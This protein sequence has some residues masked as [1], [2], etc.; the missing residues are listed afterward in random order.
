MVGVKPGVCSFLVVVALFALVA[1][2]WAQETYW[3][4]E[5]NEDWNY[6][7]LSEGE[8]E[9]E[10]LEINWDNGIPDSG[11]DAYIL[12]GSNDP[13]ISSDAWA[14][15]LYLNKTLTIE[16]SLAV[17]NEMVVGRDGMGVV[18]Q[19]GG[20]VNAPT[21]IIG[22]RETGEA[23]GEFNQT[24]G[25]N[26]FDNL[27]LGSRGSD[28]GNGTYNLNSS[29][30]LNINGDHLM[31]G[32]EGRGHFNHNHGYI[33]L[34][35]SAQLIIGNQYQGT[36][37]HYSGQVYT[38][39]SVVLGRLEGSEGFYNMLTGDVSGTGL[40]IGELG[41]NYGD[42]CLILGDAGT[43]IFEQDAGYVSVMDKMTLGQQA[44][45][46]GTYAMTES[47]AALIVFN[48]L[49]VGEKGQGFMSQ[50][51]GSLT[52]NNGGWG[53]G[54]TVG[55]DAGSYGNFE[56]TGGETIVNGPMAVGDAGEGRFYQDGG[57]L[58]VSDYLIV[59]AQT[60]SSGTIIQELQNP[61]SITVGGGGSP[62]A[63]LL[64]VGGDGYG[65]YQM[66]GGSLEVDKLAIGTGSDTG[67]MVINGS[68]ASVTIKKDMTI[69]ENGQFSAGPGATIHMTGSNFYNYS[70]DSFNVDMSN[71]TM[72]FEGGP[73]VI[74]TFEVGGP[75]FLLG[76]LQIGGT[77]GT[78]YVQL[79]D[80]FDND[81]SGA[82]G[83]EALC[84][85]TLIIGAG[86]TLDLNGV[87]FFYSEIINNGTIINSQVPVPPSI[88]LLG[89]GLV[90]LLAL[91][92]RRRRRRE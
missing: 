55:K 70:Q 91:G 59:G 84:V 81:N 51:A 86:S 21:L 22:D 16:S 34:N 2:G 64:K 25:T 50:E 63:G 12:G 52:A 20:F 15:N 73:G 89:T 74:D 68:T 60:G 79:V 48:E 62:D 31:V 41:A 38:A 71:L 82:L 88:L 37:D 23:T 4:G 53:Y 32:D 40:R 18:N 80:L 5:Y 75:N 36:Y 78:G 35:N 43:G 8:G 83:D 6:E 66:W 7:Y 56:Q 58:Q 17:S 90:G 19:G 27:V 3:T 26:T 45:G 72:V 33:S 65:E 61:G 92:G 42:R 47:S 14:N 30:Y 87:G 29:G 28:L 46:R 11:T 49:Y 54:L 24:G 10:A 39:G 1:T 85:A 76:T 69:G 13:V 57:S 67:R 77:E 9:P 44:S